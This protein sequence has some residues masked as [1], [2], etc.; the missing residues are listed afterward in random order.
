MHKI[1][2]PGRSRPKRAVDMACVPDIKSG[3]AI[4]FLRIQ[5]IR[6]K[7]RTT[8]HALRPN[9]HIRYWEKNGGQKRCFS[10]KHASLCIGWLPRFFLCL[11]K[12]ALYLLLAGIHKGD[13]LFINTKFL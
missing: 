2:S 7:R 13:D 6:K 1:P 12:K 3:D 8:F 9:T 11:K 5:C 4:A 10:E